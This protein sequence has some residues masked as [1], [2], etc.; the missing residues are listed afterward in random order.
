M[1]SSKG[2]DIGTEL[3]EQKPGETSDCRNHQCKGPV[4]GVVE[5]LKA[6]RGEM[7]SS[8]LIWLGWARSSLVSYVGNLVFS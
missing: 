6:M 5:K 8:E 7:V 3:E 4:P 1:R 2:S